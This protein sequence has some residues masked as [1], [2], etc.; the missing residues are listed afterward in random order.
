MTEI[1]IGKKVSGIGSSAFGGIQGLKAIYNRNPVPQQLEDHI[2][3]TG[4][5]ANIPPLHVPIGSGE[6]YIAANYWNIF[7]IKED[8]NVANEHIGRKDITIFNTSGGLS[9]S[10]VE[11]VQVSVFNVSG[12]VVYQKRLTGQHT[13]PLKRGFYFIKADNVTRKIYVK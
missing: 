2:V 9:I 5:H 12:Q 7:F 11:S 6:A 1:T 4:P 3:Y 13:I 10:C 8:E